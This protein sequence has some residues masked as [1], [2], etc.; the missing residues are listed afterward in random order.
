GYTVYTCLMAGDSRI[1]YRSVA[2]LG[3]EKLRAM[4][5]SGKLPPGTPLRQVPISKT[6]GISRTPVREAFARLETDGLVEP[7]GRHGV[8]VAET[9][10]SRILHAYEA[11][12]MLEPPATGKAA[13]LA[14]SELIAQLRDIL[15]RGDATDDESVIFEASRQFHQAIVAAV[16]NPYLDRLFGSIWTSSFN[17]IRAGKEAGADAEHDHQE[18]EA[19]WSAIV[20]RNPA[21]AESLM[22]DHVQGAYDVL[23]SLIGATADGHS[24]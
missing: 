2:D 22:R 9:N 14:T 19:I 1:V 11:R 20:A 23:V 18:H 10:L 24:R 3:Y 7:L 5:L 21:R 17:G 13:E 8:I 6:L 16:G 12:L 15:D 4:I